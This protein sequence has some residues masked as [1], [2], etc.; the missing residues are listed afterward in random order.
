MRPKGQHKPGVS[1]KR[2]GHEV[3]LPRETMDSVLRLLEHQTSRGMASSSH[4]QGR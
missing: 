3:G 2:G 4:S 1:P